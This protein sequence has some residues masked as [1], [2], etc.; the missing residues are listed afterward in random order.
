MVI[1]LD[2]EKKFNDFFLNALSK[3]VKEIKENEKFIKSRIY[4][5]FTNLIYT[6]IVDDFCNKNFADYQKFLYCLPNERVKEINIYC[7]DREVNLYFD[8]DYNKKQVI[9]LDFYIKFES[10]TFIFNI[11]DDSFFFCEFKDLSDKINI[12]E[13]IKH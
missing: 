11:V 1:L 9:S 13:Y 6:I 5:N 7:I 4:K 10:T 3:V 8:G 2:I 12:S